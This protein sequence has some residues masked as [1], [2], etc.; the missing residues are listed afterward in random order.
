MEIV[1]I[2]RENPQIEN[3]LRDCPYDILKKWEVEYYEKDD[4]TIFIL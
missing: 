3:I 4:M 1:E 2:L